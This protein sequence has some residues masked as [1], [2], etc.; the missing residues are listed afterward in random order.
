[1]ETD[2]P[3]PWRDAATYP[4]PPG[5]VDLFGAKSLGDADQMLRILEVEPAFVLAGFILIV[6][7]IY[8]YFIY[9]P[10]DRREPRPG[11]FYLGNIRLGSNPKSNPTNGPMKT[12]L[13]TDPEY[14]DPSAEIRALRRRRSQQSED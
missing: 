3:P 2:I 4:D 7:I 8:R 10:V 14:V 1:M 12:R 13:E 9:S 5:L 11:S 6:F